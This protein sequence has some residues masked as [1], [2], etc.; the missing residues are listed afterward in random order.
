MKKFNRADITLNRSILTQLLLV[1]GALHSDLHGSGFPDHRRKSNV[2]VFRP[3]KDLLE[4]GHEVGR[5]RFVDESSVEGERRSHRAERSAR[6]AVDLL[7]AAADGQDGALRRVDDGRELLDA[8]HA[9][10]GDGK[11]ASL[12]G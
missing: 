1:E 12:Q 9:Q 2:H 5:E 6:L 8:E 4:R 11:R 10:V 3:L 7:P